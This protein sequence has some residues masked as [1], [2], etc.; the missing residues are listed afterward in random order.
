MSRPMKAHPLQEKAETVKLP[1]LGIRCFCY[2]IILL[3]PFVSVPCSTYMD[4]SAFQRQDGVD[5][6]RP[7]KEGL[8]PNEM[9][10]CYHL[11]WRLE[12][13]HIQI[14]YWFTCILKIGRL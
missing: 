2:G 8:L 5:I 13:F 14:G 6:T 1:D 9:K 4:C 12:L 7:K 11:S 3:I 10:V